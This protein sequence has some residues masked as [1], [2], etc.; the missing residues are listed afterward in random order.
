[1]AKY[2]SGR[3]KYFDEEWE[4]CRFYNQDLEYDDLAGKYYK[5]K[6]CYKYSGKYLPTRNCYLLKLWEDWVSKWGEMGYTAKQ[7]SD[8]MY[9]DIYYVRAIFYFSNIKT[10]C[11]TPKKLTD[12]ILKLRDQGK[13]PFEIAKDLNLKY[14]K[15]RYILLKN[16]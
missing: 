9:L 16:E 4:C 8:T 6:K 12:K 13:R 15:V 14:G 11:H 10:T 3:C 1:M 5:I 2:C 7:I